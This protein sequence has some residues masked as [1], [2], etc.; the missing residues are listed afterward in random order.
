MGNTVLFAVRK[1][2]THYRAPITFTVSFSLSAAPSGRFESQF[3][4][5]GAG[6][7]PMGNQSPTFAHSA[8]TARR[9]NG[10]ARDRGK[11]FGFDLTHVPEFQAEVAIWP[12][13]EFAD[14]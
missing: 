3:L 5:V 9:T 13:T 7:F 14:G 2:R 4:V 6:R 12:A 10:F 8:A 1:I 11:L